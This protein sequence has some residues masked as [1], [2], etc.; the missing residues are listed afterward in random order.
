MADL[1]E[2]VN[3]RKSE[4][5]V[6]DKIIAAGTINLIA[7]TSGSGKTTFLMQLLKD[8]EQGKAVLGGYQSFSRKWIYVSCDRGTLETDRTMRRLGLGDWECQIYSMEEIEGTSEPDILRL[9]HRFPDVELFVI[10]GIQSCIPDSKGSQN[11]AEMLWVMK[12]RREMLC[13]NKT[14]I[15]TIHTPK[16]K[17]NEAYINGRSNMLGSASLSGSISTLISIHAAGDADE[18]VTDDR[19]VI[20]R[21]RDT[22]TF[23]LAYSR[24]KQ[25]RFIEENDAQAEF[26]L[27]IKLNSMQPGQLFKAEEMFKIGEEEGWYKMKVHRWLTK[28][29]EDGVIERVSKGQYRKLGLQ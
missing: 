10:E 2:R 6:I 23:K 13:H 12:L 7:G 11:R 1:N 22:P 29:I 8:W 15:G 17:K 5:W 28:Q 3:L 9:Y 16:M 19:E 25:G 21:P 24:D 14:I 18:D 20:V 4:K 26:K 27:E